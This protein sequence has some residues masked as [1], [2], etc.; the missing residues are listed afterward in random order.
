MA[1]VA[2][3]VALNYVK[4]NPQLGMSVEMVYVE[5]NRTESKD[6]LLACN[7]IYNNMLVFW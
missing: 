6:L 3:E 1:N 5:G 7:A 2:I 4:K